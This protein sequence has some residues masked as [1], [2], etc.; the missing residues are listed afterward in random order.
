MLIGISGKLGSGKNTVAEIIKRNFPKYKFEEE[1]FAG[2]LKKIASIILN[3]DESLMY[4]QEGKNIYLEDWGMTVGEFQQKI[5]TEG[6][7]YGV[8][9]NGWVIS[10]MSKYSKEKNW[11]VTDLRFKNEAQAILDKDGYLVRVEGDPAYVRRDSSRDL[12][13]P[14]ETDLDDWKKWN[15]II[16]NTSTLESLERTVVAGCSNYFHLDN[17]PEIQ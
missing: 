16:H 2:N 3:L 17:S 5:G 4:T 12:N 6:M 8:H 14:S 13:H 7:R 15:L 11:L 10:L 9:K 1:S